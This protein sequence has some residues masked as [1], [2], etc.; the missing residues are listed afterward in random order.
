M[1]AATPS[2]TRTWAPGPLQR[3][4]IR[5]IGSQ[6]R[7]LRQ[8]ERSIRHALGRQ[9][10]GPA[11]GLDVT[12]GLAEQLDD[13][14]VR[15]AGLVLMASGREH[16]RALVPCPPREL[17]RQARLADPGLP[18]DHGQAAVR[19]CA[20]VRADQRRQLVLPSHERQLGRRLAVLRGDC[21][22]GW[23]L[24]SGGWG[25]GPLA[26]LVVEGRGLLDRRHAQLLTQR[27]N[28]LPVLLQRAGAVPAPGVQADQ[29]AMGGLVERIE[30]EPAAHVRD[31]LLVVA[32]SGKPHRQA[33][34][35]PGE[36]AF[37]GAGLADLPVVE[38]GAVAEREALEEPGG[39]QRS[40]LGQR[41]ER[42][43]IRRE[44]PE[45]LH[46]EREIRP[47]HQGDAVTGGV[48]RLL[49]DGLAQRRQRAPERAARM[50]RI[51]P[52]P[53]QL[54]ERLA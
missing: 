11:A 24:G 27:S 19:L 26:H 3:Q 29:F 51:A 12:H 7:E 33:P 46:V 4:R 6:A 23:G 43:V 17:V 32:A 42:G 54:A 22:G 36:L 48:D 18:L 5:H 40:G 1:T 37:Q 50:L 52:G 45:A 25:Q 49:A 15:E 31:R 16:H 35:N 14:S 44:L 9:N 20:G 47:G 53:E 28:A 21:R 41:F 8:K 10:R 38:G 13:G 34:Q 2:N 39:A 30:L